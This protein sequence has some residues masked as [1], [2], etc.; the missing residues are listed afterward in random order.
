MM[1]VS[2]SLAFLFLPVGLVKMELD[3]ATKARH[4]APESEIFC[5][6]ITFLS[7]ILSLAMD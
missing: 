6:F 5:E 7:L 1:N 4:V 3:L 2:T